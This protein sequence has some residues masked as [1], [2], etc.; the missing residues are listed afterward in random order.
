VLVSHYYA[1]KL[2]GYASSLN[3]QPAYFPVNDFKALLDTINKIVVPICDNSDSTMCDPK[4]HGYCG[5]SM[6]CYCP[7]CTATGSKCEANTCTVVGNTTAGCEKKS[8]KPFEDKCINFKCNPTTGWDTSEKVVCDKNKK[9]CEEE[10]CVSATGCQ[11]NR[12]LDERCTKAPNKCHVAKCDPKNSKADKTTGCTYTDTC[13]GKSDSRY[14]N[15][16][17]LY[18]CINYICQDGRCVE[19]DACPGNATEGDCMPMKCNRDTNQCEIAGE[20]TKTCSKDADCPEKDKC[21]TP[22]CNEGGSCTYKPK[23]A[24]P[25]C[26]KCYKAQCNAKSGMYELVYAGCGNPDKCMT[27]T[28]TNSTGVC[29]YTPRFPYKA[30]FDV[31]CDK[32]T[33]KGAGYVA[34]NCSNPEVEKGS[35]IRFR[36]NANTDTCEQ[37]EADPNK[38]CPN[39]NPLCVVVSCSEQGSMCEY[40]NRTAEGVTQCRLSKC[41][42]ATGNLSLYDKCDDGRLCTIDSCDYEGNCSYRTNYCENMPTANLTSCFYWSCSESRKNGC[43]RKIFENAYFDECGNCI[44]PYSDTRNMTDEELTDCKKALTWE[45]KAAV[46][47]AGVAGAIV[48]ACIIGAI[49]VSVGGTLLTRELIKRARAAADSG[50]VENPM[51]QDNGREMSNPAFEGEDA[52]S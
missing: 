12:N 45:E 15:S 16:A 1:N 47:S 34:R 31:D 27:E 6:S 23:G 41:D 13:T 8:T 40:T 10:V 5:C 42:P 9:T 51:Y 44:G 3:G 52:D 28:C 29:E 7:T 33:G 24:L 20:S 37:Y 48:A 26:N 43:Y 11:A 19:Q 50:A 14:K 17:G 21:S 18:G 35:C 30:C 39:D 2:K 36:C 46:I 38:V 25:T 49:G 4:C 22:H 32:S